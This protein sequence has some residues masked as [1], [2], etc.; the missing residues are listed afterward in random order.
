[1]QIF[2]FGNVLIKLVQLKCITD[3]GLGAGHPAAGGFGGP[4]GEA[5][6]RWVIFWNFLEK[7][8]IWMPL[9]HISQVFR[10]IWKH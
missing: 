4:V 1:M 2:N 5:P 7:K 9:N 10:A 3:G 6:S 8:A